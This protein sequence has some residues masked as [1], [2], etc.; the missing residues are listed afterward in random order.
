MKL[1]VWGTGCGAGELADQGLDLAHITAF[2]DSAHHGERFLGKPVLPPEALVG[3]QA[4]LIVVASR[5]SEAI[6]AQ[7]RALGLDESR[8]FFTR[9]NWTLSDRNRDYAA[10]EGVLGAEFLRTLRAPQH[11]VRDPLWVADSP[12]SPRDL[13]NDYVRVR[14]LEAL[15]QRLGGVAGAAAELGVYRGGFARCI[16]ALLPERALYLFDTFAGFDAAEA[17]S[18]APGLV[19]AHRLTGAEQVL[20]LM[21]HPER[22]VL[23][24]GV[25]P[26][27]LGGLEERFCL[28]SLDVDLEESTLAG[29]RYFVPRLS[30]GGYLL[31]HDWH[32][33]RLAGVERALARYEAERRAPLH[34]VPL[35]DINGSLVICG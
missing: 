16:N 12:L 3:A 27:S 18:A 17:A 24:P 2:I 28:V 21:P 26:A 6:A 9:A 25:F 19:A 8:L 35:C 10:A 11:A 14:T 29:L 7:A 1:Y 34:A 15:C 23:R 32:T 20:R 22:V 33:P 5:Q 30:P 31:L 13:E 4:D